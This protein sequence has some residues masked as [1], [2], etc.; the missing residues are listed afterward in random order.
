MTALAKLYLSEREVARML[1]RDLAWLKANLPT[2]IRQYGF[3]KIDTAVGRYHREAVEEWARERNVTRRRAPGE[4][5][6]ETNREN[7]DAL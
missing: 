1:G 6:N 3:P 4:R 7:R 5:L 2:M